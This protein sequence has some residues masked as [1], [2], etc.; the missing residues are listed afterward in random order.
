MPS[1]QTPKQDREQERL[2]DAKVS[3][4]QL[5][6][7]LGNIRRACRVAGI[8]RSSFYEIK[9]AYEQ[10]GRSGLVPRKRGSRGQ[11]FAGPI[12]EYTPRR[13]LRAW[14]S[15]VVSVASF[16]AVFR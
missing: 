6:Q 13:V 11:R 8:S 9:K 3:L 15:P 16:A 7:E 5:S 4:L 10:F 1:D 12:F 2:I 14:K